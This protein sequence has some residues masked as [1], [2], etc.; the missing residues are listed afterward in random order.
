MDVDIILIILFILAIITTIIIY[1]KDNLLHAAIFFTIF[2]III[3]FFYISLGY[4]LLGVFQLSFYSV[5]MAA[6]FFY[7]ISLT[8]GEYHK[9]K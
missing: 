2:N 6:L 8:G 5:S 3:G 7:T 9:E 1:F 4:T